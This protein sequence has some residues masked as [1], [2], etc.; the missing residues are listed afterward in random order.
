MKSVSTS[1][2][3][4]KL[5]LY[6][7]RERRAEARSRRLYVRPLPAGKPRCF[8]RP[9]GALD[10]SPFRTVSGLGE[11]KPRQGEVAGALWQARLCHMGQTITRRSALADAPRRL[12]PSQFRSR[13]R[14][15]LAARKAGGPA[16]FPALSVGGLR[17]TENRRRMKRSIGPRISVLRFRS[18]SA[19]KISDTKRGQKDALYETANRDRSARKRSAG[20]RSA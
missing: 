11:R 9:S 13:G 14:G 2:T 17:R 18:L 15:P 16:H 1:P 19:R 5:G 10:R 6:P 7:R 3:R 12:S 20:V 8:S 4:A